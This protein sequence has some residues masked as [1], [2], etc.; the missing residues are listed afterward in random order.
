MVGHTPIVLA[1]I[2]FLHKHL[3]LVLRISEM[4][5]INII[6]NII[7]KLGI[8]V[9]FIT[10]RLNLIVAFQGLHIPGIQ[11]LVSVFV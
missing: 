11:I 10:F 3:V 1:R 8:Q 9:F 5:K 7:I 4:Y 6:I 2:V